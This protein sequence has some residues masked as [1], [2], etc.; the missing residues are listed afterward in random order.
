MDFNERLP[1]VLKIAVRVDWSNPLFTWEKAYIASVFSLAAYHH[2][3]KFE[4]QN[5]ERAKLIPCEE[6]QAIFASSSFGAAQRFLQTQDAANFFIIEREKVVVVIIKISTVLFVSLRGTQSLYD[7]KSDFD[8]R[9]V[10]VPPDKHSLIAFH[11]GFFEAVASCLR[12]VMSCVAERLGTDTPLYITGHSLGG[13]MAAI[14][15]AQ[16]YEGPSWS[17]SHY[18][19]R[20]HLL[21]RSCYAFGMPRYGN[22]YA[23]SHLANPFHVFNQRD[24]V[25]TVPP[26][27]SGFADSLDEYCLTANCNLLRPYIKGSG[28]LRLSGRHSQILGASEHKMERYIERVERAHKNGVT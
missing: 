21:P 22:R 14:L 26:R 5:T 17:S 24:G 4:I 15:N 1:H 12:E 6:Y 10:R 11:R 3:P 19:W 13:A 16:L 23:V 18:W 8:F 2:I 9:K 20:R 7:L 27:L 25:P 28:F